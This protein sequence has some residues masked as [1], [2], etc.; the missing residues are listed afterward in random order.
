VMGVIAAAESVGARDSSFTV[1]VWHQ[2]DS[3]MSATLRGGGTLVR[4]MMR[5]R[6]ALGALGGVICASGVIALLA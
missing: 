2:I 1:S 4:V 3:A 5:G 6:G